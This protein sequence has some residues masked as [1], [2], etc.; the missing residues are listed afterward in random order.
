MKPLPTV[1]AIVDDERD[2]DTGEHDA[3]DAMMQVT[4]THHEA[5]T[6]RMMFDRHQHR[7]FV[8]VR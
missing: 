6:H 5:W 7:F 1:I 4:T 2:A 8:L 3:C